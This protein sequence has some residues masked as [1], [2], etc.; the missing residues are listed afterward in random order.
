MKTQIQ[1]NRRRFLPTVL[2][3]AA[4]L[5][6]AVP[7]MA[8][9]IEVGGAD[10]LPA[11]ACPNDATCRAVTGV[12]GYQIQIGARKNPF[13]I[14]SSGRVVALTL[15]LPTLTDAQNKFFQDNYEG[16]PKVKVAI[17]R[18]R[19]RRGV[20]YRY[21]L[22]GQSESIDVSNYLGSDPM[23]PLKTSLTVR[24]GD[25]VALTVETWVP[26]FA[27]QQDAK[28]TW[29]A[30][31]DKKSCKKLDKATHEKQGQIRVYGCAYTTA[32]LLYKA[33]V[34]SAPKPSVTPKKK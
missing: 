8:A 24:R 13:L 4:I 2:A 9:I 7:A 15:K 30:S 21:V 16:A 22:A 12:T 33:T 28:T 25:V 3:I 29:R 34:I 31:R 10:P 32:Q 14:H 26:A 27:I 19:K 1:K 5:A 11:P 23:F 17:L 6:I 18:P 20:P